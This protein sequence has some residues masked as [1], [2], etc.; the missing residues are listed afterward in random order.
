MLRSICYVLCAFALAGSLSG[1][2]GG[3]MGAGLGA[4]DGGFGPGGK[5]AQAH[6][7]WEGATAAFEKAIAAGYTPAEAQTHAEKGPGA[8]IE[9]RDYKAGTNLLRSLEAGNK[10]ESERIL[11]DI[12]EKAQK[13][14]ICY[15]T[16]PDGKRVVIACSH[17]Q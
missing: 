13:L 11:R 8:T 14:D 5:A 4:R 16:S 15:D 1:C 2:F 6:G 17:K 3:A 9:L 7:S 12:K 10:A